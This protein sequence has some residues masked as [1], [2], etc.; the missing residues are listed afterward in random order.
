VE[1]NPHNLP[2]LL[3][4]RNRNHCKFEI[5]HGAAGGVEKSMRIYFGEN[6]LT[7]SA[8]ATAQ[9]W[10]EVPTVK[11]ADIVQT[12]GFERCALMCDIEG[13]EIE[14]IR[15]EI[16]T[17]RSRV[18]VFIVEFHPGISGLGTVEETRLL[19]KRQGF[20]EAWHEN[21]VFAYQNSALINPA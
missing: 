19:L 15:A 10:V 13:S 5:L 9:D 6:A 4:N 14:M 11:L 20:A 16:D 21:D 2:I 7:A 3:E 1:A 8:V 12:R 18:E 17:L